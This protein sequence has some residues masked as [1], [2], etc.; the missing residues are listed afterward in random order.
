MIDDDAVDIFSGVGLLVRWL[1]R[2][3]RAM[4]M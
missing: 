3:Q 4:P 1:L 2:I